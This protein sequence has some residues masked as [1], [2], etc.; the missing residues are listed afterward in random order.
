MSAIQKPPKKNC[1]QTSTP[2]S[3]NDRRQNLSRLPARLQMCPIAKRP[4]VRLQHQP[5]RGKLQPW[6][7]ADHSKRTPLLFSRPVDT[8]CL[9][10]SSL[11][12]QSRALYRAESIY[13]GKRPQRPRRCVSVSCCSRAAATEEAV[14]LERSDVLGNEREG[15]MASG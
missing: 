6:L 12:N 2:K 5:L 9:S 4:R 11:E 1:R 13:P 8:A 10:R 15:G 3:L 7:T 14:P